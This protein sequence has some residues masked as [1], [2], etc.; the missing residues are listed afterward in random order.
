M[1]A[2]ASTV[3]ANLLALVLVHR[4]PGCTVWYI[5]IAYFFYAV[6]IVCF[7]LWEAPTRVFCSTVNVITYRGKN[8]E[9]LCCRFIT[10]K[11]AEPL[12]NLLRLCVLKLIT[13]GLQ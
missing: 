8:K 6:E 11:L 7:A 1:G 4:Q 12:I 10:A 3:S 5:S 2:G 9:F 13:F